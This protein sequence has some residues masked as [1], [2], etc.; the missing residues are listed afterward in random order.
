MSFGVMLVSRLQCLGYG[1]RARGTKHFI[2]FIFIKHTFLRKTYK[3]SS[4]FPK[5]QGLH[6]I[7][8]FFKLSTK[9][10]FNG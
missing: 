8:L 5:T 6:C 10:L 7:Y 3:F 1:Y 9:K 2:F 4:G